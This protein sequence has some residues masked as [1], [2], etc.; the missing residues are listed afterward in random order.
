MAFVHLADRWERRGFPRPA[1]LASCSGRLVLQSASSDFAQMP[2]TMLPGGAAR[3]P[4]AGVGGQ[5]RQD[6]GAPTPPSERRAGTPAANVRRWGTGSP[7]HPS[8]ASRK[9][10]ERSGPV[11]RVLFRG[12]LQARG[13]DHFSRTQVARGLQQPTRKLKRGGSPRVALALAGR[14]L[15]PAWPCSRWGFPSQAGHPTCW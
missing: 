14:R 11:S 13:G 8:V 1:F 9:T 5:R 15:L 2:L 3:A 12:P 4:G 10:K 7:A 6:A